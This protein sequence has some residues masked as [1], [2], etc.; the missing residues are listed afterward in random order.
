MRFH[1][2]WCGMLPKPRH[3]DITTQD[4]IDGKHIQFK[5]V[6]LYYLKGGFYVMAK[7]C[8]G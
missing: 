1:G 3:S 6:A 2:S 7:L 5:N 8:R 4:L